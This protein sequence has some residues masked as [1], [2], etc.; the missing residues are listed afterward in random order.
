MPEGIFSDANPF[1]RNVKIINQ[2]SNKV[3]DGLEINEFK[4][5]TDTARRQLAMAR[6]KGWAFAESPVRK[7][8]IF[9]IKDIELDTVSGDSMWTG[10]AV[11]AIGDETRLEQVM[12]VL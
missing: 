12:E 7:P 11:I 5:R 8:S 4:L 3:A 6:F 9:T 1:S 2:S 10:V